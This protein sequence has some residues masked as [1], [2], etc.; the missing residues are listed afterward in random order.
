MAEH[1][2]CPV[3][4]LAEGDVRIVEVENRSIGVFNT[5]G[6]FYALLNECPHRGAPLCEGSVTGLKTSPEPGEIELERKGEILKCPW[7]GWEFDITN[8]K[9]VVD[10]E[11]IRTM[12]YDVTVE[13][14]DS[15]LF[16]DMAENPEVETYDVTVEDGLVVLH[17]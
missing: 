16:D 7:H 3:D 13:S 14:P 12:T 1:V 6:E 9:S 11:K 5:G 15:D 8:G 4:E 17:V 10:P 2:V